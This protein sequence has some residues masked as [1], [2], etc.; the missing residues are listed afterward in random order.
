M[1]E[2][3]VALYKTL[4]I[5]NAFT[6]SKGILWLHNLWQRWLDLSPWNFVSVNFFF[7]SYTEL[8]II[9]Y[10]IYISVRFGVSVL[11][12]QCWLIP[13]ESFNTCCCCN[14]VLRIHWKQHLKYI[15]IMSNLQN[16]FIVHNVFFSMLFYSL[17]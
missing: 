9:I 10:V 1:P 2:R 7:L 11:Q 3:N 8:L 16:R 17:S 14:T 13:R 6:I 4:W 15:F 12:N 5:C